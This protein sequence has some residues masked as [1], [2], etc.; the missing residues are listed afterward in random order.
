MTTTLQE[1]T[2]Q[3]E[4]ISCP[5]FAKTYK[6][7]D[8]RVGLKGI[9]CL[10]DLTLGPALGGIRIQPYPDFAAALNDVQR[11]ASGMTYKSAVASCSWGGGKSVIIAD[12]KQKTEELL[13][14][15]GR[16]IERLQGIYIGAEDS[17]TSPAD[18]L[19]MNAE[20]RY[21]VGLPHEKSSGNP[22]GFTAW[23]VFRGIQAALQE[24]YG[25]DSVRGKTVAIQGTGSVGSFL[26]DYL[27]WNGAHLIL[28]DV[29][30]ERAQELARKYGAKFCEPEEIYS[31]EC[32]VLAPCAFG[33][34]INERTIP[35]LRCKIIAGAA[36]NQLLTAEDGETLRR[37]GILY[38]PDFVINAGGLINV[39]EELMPEGYCPFRSRA[40]V[41]ALYD[42][43]M[44]I[45]A[46][47]KESK[48]S[49]HAAAKQLGDA[50]LAEKIGIRQVPPCFHH[51]M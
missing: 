20:T 32:D 31:Q 5:G 36:N 16:A 46:L 3:L 45:F 42:Q 29:N 40:K 9:I 28:T 30:R 33:G 13:L 22:S 25:S 47:A 6:V 10:H 23:G 48:I 43:L 1:D 44:K 26:A 38:A 39:T 15:F 7:E 19:V 35:M 11:L 49:T 34:G 50:L 8:S 14:S 18:I 2:L 24:V 21:L 27:F 37:K 17:G 51:S 41:D 12:P 4:E